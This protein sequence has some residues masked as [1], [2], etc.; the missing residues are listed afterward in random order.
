LIA[1]FWVIVATVPSRYP[2]ISPSLPLLPIHA[3]SAHSPP[4]IPVSY[5]RLVL[6]APCSVLRAPC[7]VLRAPCSVLR[8]PCSVLRAPC[9]VLRTP[10]SVLRAPC[11]VLRTPSWLV[12]A[13][14]G[15]N[16]QRQRPTNH[17]HTPYPQ[18]YEQPPHPP[19]HPP[20][21]PPPTPTPTPS[22][23]AIENGKKKRF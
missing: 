9:S 6:R 13:A 5:S 1:D 17:R 4:T 8:A 20:P 10:C 14:L 22:V 16:A 21:T 3:T 12:L 18:N 7:S 19:L 15:S 23:T 11:S 2:A